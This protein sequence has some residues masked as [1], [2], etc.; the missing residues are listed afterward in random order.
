MILV[1]TD[2]DEDIYAKKLSRKKGISVKREHLEVGDY[3]LGDGII[4]ERKRGDDFLNSIQDNRLWEQA[5]NLVQTEHP[6]IAIVDNNIWKQMYF[7]RG[8]GTHKGFYG[9][10]SALTTSYGISVLFFGDD[11]DFV[12]YVA[13]TERRLMKNKPSARPSPVL[14]KPKSIKH[15]REDSICSVRG[16]SVKKAAK[17]LEHFGTVKNVANAKEEDFLEIDGIG[18]GIAKNIYDFY[19]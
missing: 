4:I 7:R 2:A 10:I 13:T 12:R 19:R 17:I 8:H 3:C 5:G 6:I 18:K 11:D 9:A 1:E 16:I 15:C 14:R